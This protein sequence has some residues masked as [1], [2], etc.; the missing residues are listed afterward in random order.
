MKTFIFSFVS[1]G[2]LFF[3]VPQSAKAQEEISGKVAYTE[4]GGPGVLLSIN[5]DSRIKKGERLGLG[6]RV[7]AGFSIHDFDSTDVDEWGHMD[8]DTRSYYTI[9]VGLNYVL[10]K[11]YSPHMLEVGAGAT[12]L[13][14]KVSLFYYEVDTPG[15]FIGHVSFMYRCVP[16]DGGFSFRIGFTPVIGTSGD[17]FPM[18]AIGFGYAF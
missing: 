5:Y 18:G 8:Y 1:L 10:G 4:L 7:G 11:K 15:H 14:R 13:T 12:F 6:Y 3:C 2:I 9:P 16:L 17:I